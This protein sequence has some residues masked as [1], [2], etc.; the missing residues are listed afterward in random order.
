MTK[1]YSPFTPGMIV[2]NE[3]FVGRVAEINKIVN[4]CKKAKDLKTLERIFVV[5]ERGIG[6][7]SICNYARTHLEQKHEILGLHIFLGGVDTL[8]EMVRRIF[9]RLLNES[10]DKPWNKVIEKFLGHHVKKV[11]MFGVTVEFDATKKDLSAAVNDFVPAMRNLLKELKKEKKSILLILDDLNGLAGSKK[12]AN[13]LKSVVDEI[14]TSNKKLPLTLVLVGLPERREELIASQ[15]SLD[16]VFDLIDI[17][18]FSKEETREFFKKAFGK[19]NMKVTRAADRFLWDFSKGYPVFMHEIGD[20]TFKRASKQEIDELIAFWGCVD[21]AGIIGAKYIE[22]KVLKAIRSQNY[23]KILD[24]LPFDII[25][26]QFTRTECLKTLN[27]EEAKVF[28]NFINRMKKLDVIRN[29]PGAGQGQYEFTSELYGLFFYL[30]K[31]K[32]KKK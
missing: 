7:S 11:G 31:E 10:I 16:R 14:A 22:P 24:K 23:L 18:R 3:F 30:E 21:A 26:M 28:D 17:K 29:R 9:E 32:K 27:S 6:K 15:P 4:S 20:A 12:F 19:V 13:W 8:E 2:P 5:G 1:D 25:S